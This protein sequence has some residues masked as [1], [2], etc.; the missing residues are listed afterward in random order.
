ME[1]GDKIF[2]R[3][4]TARAAYQVPG[5]PDT[6]RPE[7][8]VA[9]C[10]PGLELDVRNLDRRFFPGLL[11][12]FVARRDTSEPYKTPDH[13]GARLVYVDYENDPDLSSGYLNDIEP[14]VRQWLAP[15]SAQLLADLSGA[16][17][18]QLAQGKWYIDWVEQYGKR[19]VM[20]RR[21]DDGGTPPLDGLFVWR[22]L[23]GLEFKPMTLGLRRRDAPGQ[24]ELKGWRR[25]FTHPRT[26]VISLAYQPG[27]MLQSLCSPWQHDFRD[28][29]CHYWA[30]NRP[31]IVHGEIELG[32]A[33]LPDGRAADPL[34]G[35]RLL[36]WMRADHSRGMEAAAQGTYLANR[37]FQ[38]DHYQINRTWQVLNIVVNNT[39]IG[40]SWQPLLTGHSEPY[41]S[42]AALAK[43]LSEDLAP[44]EMTLALEYLYARFSLRAP[45]EC[46]A[47]LPLMADDMLFARHV[48]ISLAVAEMEHIRAANEML[49]LLHDAKLIPNFTPV[50]SPAAL[51]RMGADGKPRP[52]QLRRLERAALDDFIAVEQ[53]SGFINGAYAKAIATLKQPIYPK[54]ILQISERIVA[55][56]TQHYEQ[57][58]DV[59]EVLRAYEGTDAEGKP[60]YPYLRDVRV[61][62][63]AEA[64]EGLALFNTILG[65]LNTAYQDM[66]LRNY[67]EAGQHVLQARAA[68]AKLLDAGDRLAAAGIGIPFWPP[69]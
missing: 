11:F 55:D 10:Y 45:Q 28:C 29:S 62:S 16:K 19:I 39:E 20:N 6:S 9:N 41:E 7:D 53:P 63:P 66:S 12:N 33:V 42:P 34:R 65:E 35:R 58:R 54:N 46:P 69:P 36:D 15:L 38:M 27:E 57:F 68:M 64:K 5:N 48:V 13:Y 25:H 56:G 47:N 30:S 51:V 4:L 21:T 32:E 52:R 18:A 50:L 23:R 49:W 26:G 8:A 59:A 67:A 2:P 1:L 24:I 14:D 3:N 22:I 61:G 60:V 40:D 31:D 43:A 17:G 44:L 37:P